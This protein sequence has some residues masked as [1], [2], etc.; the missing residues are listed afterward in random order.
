MIKFNFKI[1]FMALLML[2]TVFAL[3]SN[4]FAQSRESDDNNYNNNNTYYTGSTPEQIAAS[5]A[6]QL[7]KR[8]SLTTSQYNTVYSY[9]LS[10]EQQIQSVIAANYDKQTL[11]D[12]I[13][14]I[15][16]STRESIRGVLTADQLV[17]YD[18]Y[19]NKGNDSN[20]NEYGQKKEKK[21]KKHNKKNKKDK[22]DRDD[23]DQDNDHHDKD[24]RNNDH[25]DNDD[26][27]ND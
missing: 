11:N 15:N 1:R 17:I 27:D 4:S 16:S 8:L 21:H 2:I 6:A 23:D 7:Q 22:E 20:N 24:H 9:L 13:N 25:H 12:Q 10:G 26:Q 5:K 14:K 18:R 19:N 3:S